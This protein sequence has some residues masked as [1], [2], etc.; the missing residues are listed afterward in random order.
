VGPTLQKLYDT[1]Q[2]IQ[3]GTL[4]DKHGWCYEVK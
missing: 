3:Y 1:V 4:P 2:G